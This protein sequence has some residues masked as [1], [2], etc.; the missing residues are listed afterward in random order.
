MHITCRFIK[1]FIYTYSYLKKYLTFQRETASTNLNLNT[2][3]LKVS[4]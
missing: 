3:I 4:I 2:Q 1:A